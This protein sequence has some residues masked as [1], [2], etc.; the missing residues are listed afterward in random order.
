MSVAIRGLST[1]D[2]DF[3]AAFQ[4]VLHWSDET[5]DLSLIHI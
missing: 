3:E 1:A 5:D 4:R 2:A